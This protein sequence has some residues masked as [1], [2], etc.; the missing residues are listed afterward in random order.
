MIALALGVLLAATPLTVHL[1]RPA[2][3][4]FHKLEGA[5]ADVRVAAASNETVVPLDD[6]Q[7]FV[8]PSAEGY[9]GETTLVAMPA[10]Q[11]T[12]SLHLVPATKIT[13]TVKLPDRAKAN[14]LTVYLQSAEGPSHAIAC[15]IDHDRVACAVPAGTFDVAF[16]MAGYVSL[17]RWD[18][19]LSAPKTDLGALA[20]KRGSTFSGRVDAPRDA[21]AQVE[22][23]QAT[24]TNEN[25]MIR[26]RKNASRLVAQP[27]ARGFFSFNVA[28]GR[29][30]VRATAADLISEE[31]EVVVFEGREAVLRDPLRLERKRS[32]TIN[33]DPALDPWKMHWNVTVAMLNDN[34][35]LA[36]PK[37]LAVP[38]AGSVRFDGELPGTYVISV[39][40]SNIDEWATST[41]E[42]DDDRIVDLSV[43]M[44]R[45]RGS[46][47]LGKDPLPSVV[48]FSDGNG[49]QLPVHTRPDGTFL[50]LLPTRPE[51]KWKSVDITSKTPRITRTL[52][53]IAL[54]NPDGEEA[55]LDLQLPANA[56]EGVVVDEHGLP[57]A[58][59]LVNIAA[60]DGDFKQLE[61]EDGTFS[62]SGLAPG[63]YKLTAATR[64]AESE[65]PEV[66]T[67]RDDAT[68][69]VTLPIRAVMHFRG[70]VRSSYGPIM[71][72][73]IF[74]TPA[75]A[76][77]PVI[78]AMPV[79]PDGR[80][81]VRLPSRTSDVVAAIAAPGFSLRMIHL[82]ASEAHDATIA[83]DQHGGSLVLELSD[84][85]AGMQPYLIHGG[86]VLRAN[87]VAYLGAGRRRADGDNTIIEIPQIEAG[88]YSLCWMSSP[89]AASNRCASG[90]LARDGTLKLSGAAIGFARAIK[91]EAK[92]GL[93]R[94]D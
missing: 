71:N 31:R 72:A 48:T 70:E 84:A 52:S 46:V 36:N 28:P 82:P 25:D 8:T 27:N 1:D 80:F 59:A 68:G 23:T 86:V 6:G 45:V 76:E 34:G 87:V 21:K 44:T 54:S 90:T 20:F 4:T 57:A 67:L 47:R 13:A 53:D 43:P 38:D 60:P 24:Q 66:V 41:I 65:S 18:A 77:P 94:L 74:A 29:Y 19:H 49:L 56:I 88:T 91:A 2:T 69:S 64:E 83:L 9:W 32:L 22:L 78:A 33:V 40:R 51:G 5:A 12:L 10:Q 7:W 17:Y 37:T 14:E 81:D 63:A 26:A 58:H 62:L 11:G 39:H 93:P 42:L 30:V 79:D 85:P 61:S 3:L 15:P 89:S 55:T 73:A 50:T 92:Q 35:T 75:G 16:R